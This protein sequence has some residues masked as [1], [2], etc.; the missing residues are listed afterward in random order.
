MEQVKDEKTFKEAIEAISALARDV[1]EKDG[2]HSHMIFFIL[3]D[4]PELATLLYDQVASEIAR[5]TK[6][7]EELSHADRDRV[8]ATIATLIHQ[9]RAVGYFEVGEG[10][11]LAPSTEPGTSPEKVLESYRKAKE[12][13]GFIKDMPVKLEILFVRARFR[14]LTTMISWKIMRQGKAV[15]LEPFI[16]GKSEIEVIPYKKDEIS[17]AGM[18]DQA[19]DRVLQEE[20]TA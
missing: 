6:K 15:W 10:W 2:Y 12:K 14:G 5:D 9:A 18:I 11:G 8:Y 7:G 16:Q 4:R 20:M 17:R 3:K 19:I 1:F 13:Y